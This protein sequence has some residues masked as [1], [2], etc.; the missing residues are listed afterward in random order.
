RHLASVQGQAVE[1]FTLGDLLAWAAGEPF[2]SEALRLAVADPV[3]ADGLRTNQPAALLRAGHAVFRAHGPEAVEILAARVREEPDT[4][5]AQE[6][7]ELLAYLP[8]GL[9]TAALHDLHETAPLLEGPAG[10]LLH[11][12]MQRLL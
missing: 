6:L 1:T 5:D 8:S 11:K 4:N 10:R 7:L 3:F 9:A 12:R 2:E